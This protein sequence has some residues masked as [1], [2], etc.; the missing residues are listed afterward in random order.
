MGM[1]VNPNNSEFIESLNSKIYVDKTGLLNYVNNVINTKDKF[2]C[3]SRPRRFGKSMA[4]QMMKAYYSKGCNSKELF[5]ELEIYQSP[6]FT[7]HLNNYDVIAVDIQYIRSIG[8][9]IIDKTKTN[10]V[11]FIQEKIINELKE[12]YTQFI[13]ETENSLA[14]AIE[15][16]TKATGHKFIIFIDEWDCFFRKDKNNTTLL[17]EYIRFLRGLFK[18]TIADN[19][20]SLAYMTGILPIKKYNTQS[21]L[22]NFTEFTM[23][24]QDNL[25]EYTGFTEEEVENLCNKY[26]VDFNEMKKWYDGYN[27]KFRNKIYHIYNPKSVVEAINRGD[28]KSYW[29]NTESYETLK[30]YIE[31]DFDGIKEDVVKMLTGKEIEVNTRIFQ[32]DM[33]S[34]NSKDDVFTLL[35]HLGYLSYNIY[36]ETIKIPNQEIAIE[37]ENTITA[38]NWGEI[39]EILL[40]SKKLLKATINIEEETVAKAIHETNLATTNIFN[41]NDENSLRCV[42]QFAYFTAIKDYTILPELNTGRGRADIFFLPRKH[43]SKPALLVEL[44]FDKSSNEAIQQ[45]REREYGVEFKDFKDNIIIVGINYNKDENKHTCKIEKY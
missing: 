15:S 30:T 8:F 45:I 9:D 43:C 42:I 14:N 22:N 19:C 20:I 11:K 1:Y 2:I 3:S 40:N 12:E 18:G 36:E 29:V 16:I 39:S 25:A 41:Y 34:I 37:F 26:D 28:F 4:I 44:K 32:N 21:A 35:V 27:V 24:G 13:N 7:K 23:L 31:S 33:T 38:S 5:K 17:E 6:D 10:L